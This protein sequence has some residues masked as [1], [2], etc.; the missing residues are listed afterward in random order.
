MAAVER[1]GGAFGRPRT[2]EGRPGHRP[3]RASVV[4]TGAVGL[5]QRQDADRLLT[6]ARRRRP[7]RS[8]CRPT[9]DQESRSRAKSPPAT[10]PTRTPPSS[11]AQRGAVISPI[12]NRIVVDRWSLEA[13]VGVV[14][15]GSSFGRRDRQASGPRHV[16]VGTLIDPPPSC[17]HHAGV[18]SQP[19]RDSWL[20]LRTRPVLPCRSRR[21]PERVVLLPPGADHDPGLEHGA[22]TRL[23][24]PRMP[25][26]PKP[27][28]PRMPPAPKPGT[29]S[30]V[31]SDRRI[32]RSTCERRTDRTIAPDCSVTQRA[33]E[34]VRVDDDQ[35]ATA[36]ELLDSHR[37][38]PIALDDLVAFRGGQPSV[39]T[40]RRR[41]CPA[42]SVEH[43]AA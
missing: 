18:S 4:P 11:P 2:G 14:V 17:P 25:P 24:I 5:L 20:R 42:P 6:E 1:L 31:R 10:K 13:R 12:R 22:G 38:L 16:V 35:A 39:R 40:V 27:W 33:S 36:A 29:I 9:F 28:I 41:P 26:A 34:P 43:E 8:R 37:F 23:W 21:G 3:P 7:S 15:Y 19:P 30:S 32:G